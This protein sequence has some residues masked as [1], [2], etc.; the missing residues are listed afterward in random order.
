MPSLL[1]VCMGWKLVDFTAVSDVGTDDQD[2]SVAVDTTGEELHGA[3]GS[4]GLDEAG[5]VGIVTSV[6]GDK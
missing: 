2:V 3:T 1:L 6:I 5:D 4:D